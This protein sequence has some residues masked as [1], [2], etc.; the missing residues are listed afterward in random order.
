[1]YNDS[2]ACIQH[3]HPDMTIRWSCRKGEYVV[4]ISTDAL[5]NADK[6]SAWD[7][8][9]FWELRDGDYLTITN[10]MVDLP[11]WFVLHP[12]ETSGIAAK[13]MSKQL[14]DDYTPKGVIDSPN[15]WR[16]KA[17]DRLVWASTLTPENP[18][19]S[20]LD[21]RSCAMVIGENPALQIFD[22]MMF[23]GTPEEQTLS[24]T[25]AD[26]IRSGINVAIGLGVP[27][28]YAPVWRFGT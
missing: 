26:L 10:R 18:I 6:P 23:F 27:R 22:D 4:W 15:L 3:F 20:V 9:D 11:G 25:S 24:Q 14:D 19:K 17:G 2:P 8:R 16:V 1:M 7:I 12:L 28:I 5:L 21:F 13:E